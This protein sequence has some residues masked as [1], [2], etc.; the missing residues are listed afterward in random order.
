MA[1]ARVTVTKTDDDLD[2]TLPTVAG[3]AAVG[4]VL[5]D[6]EDTSEVGDIMA[7]IETA[8]AAIFR[9]LTA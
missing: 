2:A 1:Q 5:I 9:D 8:K 4:T 3:S 7:A 6:Y